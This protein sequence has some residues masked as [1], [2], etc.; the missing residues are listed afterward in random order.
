[1]VRVSGG[2]LAVAVAC[3][4]PAP[5]SPAAPIALRVTS[6][7]GAPVSGAEVLSGSNV[8]ALTDANGAASLDVGG[9]EGDTF[10]VEVRCPPPFRS[11]APLVI[12]KLAITGGATEMTVKCEE[13]ARTLVVVVRAEG[14]PNLP[15]LHLG[16][17]V[18]RT[19]RSGAAHLKIDADN[20]ERIELT[21]STE[22]IEGIHPQ[23]PTTAFEPNENDE[24]RELAVTFTRDAKRKPHK[25]PPKGPVLF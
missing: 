2:L 16:K 24:V 20:R 15:I 25:A 19:D 6:N 23:N 22:G 4:P 10:E 8:V 14:G 3:N 21:L 5:P 7:R 9:R 13:T 1:M 18:G 12:R 17:E 11:P